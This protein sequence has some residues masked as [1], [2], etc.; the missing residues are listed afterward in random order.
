MGVVLKIGT[1]PRRMGSGNGRTRAR[2]FDSKEYELREFFGRLPPSPPPFSIPPLAA[3]IN[4]YSLP[5]PPWRPF[6]SV[7]HFSSFSFPF[8]AVAMGGGREGEEAG[9]AFIRGS[10][11]QPSLLFLSP[12]P[13]PHLIWIPLHGEEK[14]GLLGRAQKASPQ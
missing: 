11:N 3:N 9:N 6:P 14:N 13:P 1:L 7:R 8:W 2:S 12:P 5:F 4:A 10:P